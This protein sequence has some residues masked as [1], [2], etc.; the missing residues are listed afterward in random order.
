MN[1]FIDLY[2]YLKLELKK[3]KKITIYN[4]IFKTHNLERK[5]TY[6]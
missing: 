4:L 6:F 1:L 3:K 2:F 5:K